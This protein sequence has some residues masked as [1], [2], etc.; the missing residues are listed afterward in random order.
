MISVIGSLQVAPTRI[1]CHPAFI[2]HPDDFRLKIPVQFFYSDAADVSVI[3]IQGDILQL[4]QVTEYAD[5]F[6][7]R[8]TSD[9][10]EPHILIHAL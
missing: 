9:K 3:L 8:H 6:K 10:N 4:V 5:F 1:F 7:L 2:G